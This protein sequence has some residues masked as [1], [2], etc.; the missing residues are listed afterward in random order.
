M[1]SIIF[2]PAC[3]ICTLTTALDRH[4]QN[5]TA[6][7]ESQRH[8]PLARDAYFTYY[9][10]STTTNCRGW[11]FIIGGIPPHLIS[12]RKLI[13]ASRMKRT[14]NA[15]VMAVR[16]SYLHGILPSPRLWSA[17]VSRVHRRHFSRLRATTPAAKMVEVLRDEG[18]VVL[19]S[20]FTPA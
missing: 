17:A 3:L 18:C 15:I 16:I 19:E 9:I 7:Q 10:R 2:D 13:E 8:R 6:R 4:A 14:T 5:R 11:A 12:A 20:M 1:N